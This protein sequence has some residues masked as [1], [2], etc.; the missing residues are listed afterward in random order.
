MDSL[1]E[2]TTWMPNR[3]S[4][5]SFQGTLMLISK[6]QLDSTC[7]PHYHLT[8]SR[9]KYISPGDDQRSAQ[10]REA[11]LF[12]PRGFP[13]ADIGIPVKFHGEDTCALILVQVK[14]EEKGHIGSSTRETAKKALDDATSKIPDL[15]PSFFLFMSLHPN[16][17]KNNQTPGTFWWQRRVL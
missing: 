11:A 2:S 12:F 10:K 3:Y 15:G 4:S 17:C 13:G 7:M 6:I 1:Q 9:S 5:S 14:N 8:T 16:T